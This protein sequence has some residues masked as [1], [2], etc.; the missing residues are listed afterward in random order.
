[1]NQIITIFFCVGVLDYLLGDRL[2][3][4]QEFLK[5]LEAITQLLVLMA[6]MIVISPWISMIAA[7]SMAPFFSKIGCDPSLFAGLFLSSDGGGAILAGQM[8]L[9]PQAGIYNGMVV[10]SFMGITIMAI[11]PL[12]LSSTGAGRR[13]ASVYGLLIGILTLPLGCVITG[14]LAKIELKI[15]LLNT[16]PVLGI[17]VILTL[18]FVFFQRMLLPVFQAISFLVRAMALLGFS[19]GVLR[20]LCAIEP[21]PGMIPLTEVFPVI[22]NIGVY[23][24]GILVL[25]KFLQRIFGRAIAR[26]GHFLGIQEQTVAG[27]FLSA[28]NPIPIITDLDRLNNRDC[29]LTVAFSTGACFAVGDYLAFSMQFNPAIAIPLM[30]GKIITGVMGLIIGVVAAPR[31][32]NK[33]N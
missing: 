14:L 23:L 28:A 30:T 15:I 27:L 22:C 1:M 8:A 7:P 25:M 16:W 32:L 3:V 2:G 5:G 31:L 4:G 13:D 9:T 19:L 20:E 18:L 11:I 24:S 10:A 21:L 17:A 26:V 6:G 29:L 33:E 12:V